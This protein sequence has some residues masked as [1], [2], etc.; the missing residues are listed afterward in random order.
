MRAGSRAASLRAARMIEIDGQAAAASI[1]A[2]RTGRGAQP[3]PGR[4]QQGIAQV[5][6]DDHERRC[7]EH[8]G[9]IH[10]RDRVQ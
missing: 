9:H 8:P 4:K 2:L 7:P 3:R 1:G 10:G 6:V 5:Y